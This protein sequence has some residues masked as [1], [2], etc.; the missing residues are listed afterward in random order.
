[1]EEK[2]KKKKGEYERGGVGQVDTKNMEIFWEGG[3]EKLKGQ[4]KWATI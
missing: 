4:S 2:K 1:M 3:A